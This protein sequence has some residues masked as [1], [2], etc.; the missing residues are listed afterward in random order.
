MDR[1]TPGLL[2]CH[3]FIQDSTDEIYIC[4]LTNDI[5]FVGAGGKNMFN[6]TLDAKQIHNTSP[7]DRKDSKFVCSNL[8][9]LENLN[10]F[11]T[12]RSII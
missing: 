8:L 3:Q 6:M 10:L 9:Y 1:S 12:F 5:N 2:V 4:D 11:G 7:T